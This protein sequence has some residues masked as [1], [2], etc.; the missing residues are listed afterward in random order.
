[1]ALAMTGLCFS[2]M[3]IPPFAGFWAK[4]FVFKAAIGADLW[5][6]A[7]AALVGSVIAAFYYLRLVKLMWFDPAP[8]AVDAGSPWEARTVAYASA[9]LSI[10]ASL[11]LIWLYPY[12]T[13]AAQAFGLG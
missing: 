11:A 4:V 6:A 13:R 8:G 12:A 5:P 1:M 2:V 9:L 7:A 10:F 3:G